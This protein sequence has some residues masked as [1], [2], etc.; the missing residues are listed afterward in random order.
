MTQ[1]CESGS[2]WESL[3]IVERL[4][5]EHVM[6]RCRESLGGARSAAGFPVTSA[7]FVAICVS[8]P[9]LSQAVVC[10]QI[11]I[12]VGGGTAATNEASIASSNFN[13]NK[14]ENI[15]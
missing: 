9:C 8:T 14:Q 13:H 5:G 12:D 4:D 3:P 7:L 2:H 10:P 1:A 6:I 11:R 15:S